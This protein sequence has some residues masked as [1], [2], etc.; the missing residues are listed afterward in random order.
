LKDSYSISSKVIRGYR[1]DRDQVEAG[2]GKL[3][4]SRGLKKTKPLFRMDL[5]IERVNR[6]SGP[7]V[8]RP[9]RSS[10]D[11]LKLL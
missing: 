5:V 4:D 7:Q 6:S 10:R 11:E 3:K 2:T 9:E 1:S 8:S